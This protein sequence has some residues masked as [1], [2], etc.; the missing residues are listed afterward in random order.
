MIAKNIL[1]SKT[2]LVAILQ[3]ILGVI[4]ALGSQIE[5][6]GWLMVV[7]SVID[8]ALRAITTQPVKL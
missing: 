6:V 4:L 1:L 7:K 5:T 8:I 3:G 2:V